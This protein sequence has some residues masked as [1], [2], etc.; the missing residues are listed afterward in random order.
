MSGFARKDI[1]S[2]TVAERIELMADL[3]DS[4]AETPEA[5]AL[6]EAQKAELDKRLDAYQRDP[7][8]G[9]PWSTVRDRIIG[10]K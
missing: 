9:D 6:T 7:T 10:R 5:V 2:L 4:L 3:W 1:L 8:V